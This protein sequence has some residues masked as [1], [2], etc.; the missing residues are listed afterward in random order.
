MDQVA[1]GSTG[2]PISAGPAF[3]STTKAFE[4]LAGLEFVAQAIRETS[5]PAFAIGGI[6]AVT[7]EPAVKAECGELWSPGDCSSGGSACAAATL[8]EALRVRQKEGL[9]RA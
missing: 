2:H 6:N 4:T 9:K 1:G 7:I 5:L 3:P 8:C